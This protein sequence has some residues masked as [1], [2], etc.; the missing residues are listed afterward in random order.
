MRSH[1]RSLVV[2]MPVRGLTMLKMLLELLLLVEPM[3]RMLFAFRM[4]FTLFLERTLGE[5][6]G[7]V[8]FL[9]LPVLAA[10]SRS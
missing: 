6:V 7:T 10:L 8:E 1:L 5:M 3:V 9:P 4:V 2:A